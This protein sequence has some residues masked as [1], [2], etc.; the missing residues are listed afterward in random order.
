MNLYLKTLIL[1]LIIRPDILYSQDEKS[2]TV[3]FLN[4]RG[5]FF[6]DTTETGKISTVQKRWPDTLY[7]LTL[8][9]ASILGSPTFPMTFSKIER[10][11]DKFQVSPAISGGIGYAFFF[12]DFIFTQIDKIQVNQTVSFGPLFEIGLQ[13]DLN[14]EKLA[15]LIAGGF[16]G[17]GPFVL[18]FGYDFLS[19]S[20]S[21][22]IGQKIDFYTLNQNFL[23]P[24]G[25]IQEV[26]KHKS[27][28]IPIT[29]E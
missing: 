24:I 4:K 20:F 12:G 5:Y 7:Y 22:G 15:S 17:V 26:R 10:N 29:N 3:E 25:R 21:L 2:P 27:V 8:Y 16:A 9:K 6:S 1:I 11:D 19:T 14:L 23:K 18:T 28:A 13:N